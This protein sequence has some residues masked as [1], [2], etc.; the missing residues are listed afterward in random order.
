MLE[1]TGVTL[2]E[3]GTYEMNGQTYLIYSGVMHFEDYYGNLQPGVPYLVKPWVSQQEMTL[4]GVTLS[5]NAAGSVTYTLA[6]QQN[7]PGINLMANETTTYVG[8]YSLV[9][10]YSPTTLPK[11]ESTVKMI[12]NSTLS[13]TSLIDDTDIAGTEAY[14]TV[15]EGAGVKLD[16]AG[17]G[18]VTA[19][20]DI[21]QDNST[22]QEAVIYNI[23]GQRLTR[24]LSELPPG[25][26]IVNGKKIVKR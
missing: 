12:D 19:V 26:Y 10:T 3:V 5:K 1:Y 2:G 14:I 9:G 18:V 17:T 11:N 23:M 4:S 7:A 16:L 6:A 21:R 15:P 25:V 8:D 20:T 22:P 13:W 24:P